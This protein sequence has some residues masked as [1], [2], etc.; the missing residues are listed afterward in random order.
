MPAPPVPPSRGPPAGV[1]IAIVTV[2]L[3]ILFVVVA[4]ASLSAPSAPSFPG[5]GPVG[6]LTIH[7]TEIAV[8]SSDDACGLNGYNSSQPVPF[9]TTA[10]SVFALFWSLPGPTGPLPCTVSTVSTDTPGFTVNGFLPF[11]VT[12]PGTQ[13]T[14][15]LHTPSSYSGTFDV[16]FG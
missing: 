1:I 12:S 9:T 2:L 7:I 4:A 13:F 14:V 8:A 10:N 6:S 11:N 16:T 15:F 3:V 5:P